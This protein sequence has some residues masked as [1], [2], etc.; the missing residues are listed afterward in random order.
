MSTFFTVGWEP[1][2]SI[3][4]LPR[5]SGEGEAPFFTIAWGPKRSATYYPAP[6]VQRRR[7]ELGDLALAREDHPRDAE[8]DAVR[9]EHEAAVRLA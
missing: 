3:G 4:W 9:A 7:Q 8:H 6:D 5:R 1:P 2:A